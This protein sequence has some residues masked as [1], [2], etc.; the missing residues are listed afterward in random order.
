M[1]SLAYSHSFSISKHVLLLINMTRMD[2]SKA[3]GFSTEVE[4]AS[5]VEVERRELFISEL[6]WAGNSAAF[7][8]S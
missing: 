3:T 8:L 1:E 6:N 5:L 2:E 4:I 7:S